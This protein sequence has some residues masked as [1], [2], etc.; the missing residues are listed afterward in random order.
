MTADAQ[1]KIKILAGKRVDGYV[2]GVTF[3]ALETNGDW[4]RTPSGWVNLTFCERV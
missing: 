2:R 4:G 3:T 1:K